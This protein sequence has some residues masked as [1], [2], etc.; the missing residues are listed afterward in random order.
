MSATSVPPNLSPTAG[1]EDPSIRLAEVETSTIMDIQAPY[2]ASIPAEVAAAEQA[3]K[4][5]CA[6]A[7]EWAT[8]PQGAGLGGFSLGYE[9]P[10]NDADWPASLN[11]P[12]QGP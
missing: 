10:D 12:H 6:G 4:A 3:G 7:A 11:V 1:P 8:S 9:D 2:D 5:W